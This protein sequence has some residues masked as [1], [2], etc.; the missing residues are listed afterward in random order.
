M[1]KYRIL[2]INNKFYPQ[3]K[4]LF[5][6]RYLDTKIYSYTWGC[7]REYHALCSGILDAKIVIE[8][9]IKYLEKPKVTIH[10][11]KQ[12]DNG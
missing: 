8:R 12:Q 9:R 1:R 2:Q 11:Y 3:E 6:W 10:E 5:N 4:R 7:N